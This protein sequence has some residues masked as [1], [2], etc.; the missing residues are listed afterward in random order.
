LSNHK[1]MPTTPAPFREDFDLLITFLNAPAD[2]R[3]AAIIFTAYAE[4]YLGE[5][6]Q[7]RLPG[8]NSGLRK[9]LFDPSG[10]LGPLSAKIDLAKA[11][12]QLDNTLF[13]NIKVLASIR[14][15]FAHN[16]AIHSCDHPE[17]A[18]RIA[19]FRG[20]FVKASSPEAQRIAD[21]EHAQKSNREKMSITALGICLSLYNAHNAVAQIKRKGDAKD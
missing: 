8:L 16:L 17:I 11:L 7:F 10:M 18:K 12:G 4:K 2:D 6:V 19:N 15:Q 13:E 9:K 1:S 3:T 20:P 21:A 5:L 14:N